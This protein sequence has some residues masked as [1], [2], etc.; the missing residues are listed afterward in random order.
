MCDKEWKF[1]CGP[2][3]AES[4]HLQKGLAKAGT[5]S[6]KQMYENSLGDKMTNAVHVYLVS[7]KIWGNQAASGF[8]FL[9]VSHTKISIQQAVITRSKSL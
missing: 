2:A 7:S 9:K 6:R 5:A 3:I 1:T 8:N 4:F